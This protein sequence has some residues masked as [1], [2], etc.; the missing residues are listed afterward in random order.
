[1]PPYINGLVE[2]VE[3]MVLAPAQAIRLLLFCQ[4]WYE[5]LAG[6]K[7]IVFMYSYQYCRRKLKDS[8]LTLISYMRLM[9][10]GLW[11]II[12]YQC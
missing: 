1:M 8:D 7:D 12:F 9:C 2:V 6:L 11:T 3:G 5:K 4:V 10:H